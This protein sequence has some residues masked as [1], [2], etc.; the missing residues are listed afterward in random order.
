MTSLIVPAGSRIGQQ[1]T[2]SDG[3]LYRG[4]NWQAFLLALPL[5]IA[6]ARCAPIKSILGIVLNCWDDTYRPLTTCSKPERFEMSKPGKSCNP[7]PTWH[8]ATHVVADP[9]KPTWRHDSL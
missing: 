5:N 4:G 6:L 1:T 8:Y 3:K 9:S 7:R 2:S